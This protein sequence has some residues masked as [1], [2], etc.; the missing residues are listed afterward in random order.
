MEDNSIPLSETGTLF[1]NYGRLENIDLS[2]NE[3]SF[4]SFDLD[5]NSYVFYSNIY[6]DISDAELTRLKTTWKLIKE[7]K[8][9]QVRVVLYQRP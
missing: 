4:A 1:P 9:L 3:A 5:S 7:Y 8:F 6:N 2:G